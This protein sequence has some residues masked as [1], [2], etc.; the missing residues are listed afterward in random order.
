M[1][2]NQQ[3][4][5]LSQFKPKE[6]TSIEGSPH[7]ESS[8]RDSLPIKGGYNPFRLNT[9]GNQSSGTSNNNSPQQL[10]SF[11]SYH[12]NE[13]PQS[14]YSYLKCSETLSEVLKNRTS[15]EL[16]FNISEKSEEESIDLYCYERPED[17]LKNNTP[18][19]PDNNHYNN[20][21]S[22]INTM[23]I[24]EW[25][26]R[27]KYIDPSIVKKLDFSESPEKENHMPPN[28]TDVT[29]KFMNKNK[30]FPNVEIATSTHALLPKE[31]PVREF[32]HKPSSLITT[33]TNNT[34]TSNLSM[35]F[36]SKIEEKTHEP[37]LL[38]KNKK[39]NYVMSNGQEITFSY[40]TKEENTKY[41]HKEITP[42]NPYRER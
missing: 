42:Q 24:E 14:S 4:Q 6:T 8:Q 21:T 41:G 27:E 37:K 39:G 38:S 11:T 29:S 32:P 15:K 3:G 33:S 10:I 40:R 20:Y 26:K 1:N 23:Q 22:D 34:D 31:K 18:Q 13:T 7:N 25:T 5:F 19:T 17:L 35:N 36:N 2:D 9:S 12:Q 30:F 16:Y 28:K